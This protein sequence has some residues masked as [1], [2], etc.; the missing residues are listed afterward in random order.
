[1][2]DQSSIKQHLENDLIFWE[3]ALSLVT[4]KKSKPWQTKEWKKKRDELIKDYCEQCGTKQ[5]PFV[6]N[7]LSKRI[8]FR[9]IRYR[10]YRKYWEI[11]SSKYKNEIKFP[12][13]IKKIERPCCPYC[14]SLRIYYFKTKLFYTCR[15][16]NSN[17]QNPDYVSEYSSED[18]KKIAGIKAKFYKSK[19]DLFL[20]KYKDIIYKEAV[21]ES[22]DE[23]LDYIT[24]NNTATYCK[25]CAFL[26]DIR[27]LKLCKICKSKYHRLKYDSCINCR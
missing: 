4:S 14:S 27:D 5:G 24:F 9:S 6:L 3:D 12:K 15:Q 19:Y 22:I 18:K 1:M 16:C 17:F 23:H 7:H 8:P 20:S 25:K 26:Y 10:I 13:T 2:M 21:L 11:F